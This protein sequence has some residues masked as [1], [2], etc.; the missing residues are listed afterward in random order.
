MTKRD[1]FIILIKVFGLYSIISVL[2]SV[3]PINISFV[4]QNIDLVG[5]IWLILAT[6]IIIGL[7]FLLLNKAATISDI[8]KLEK[9]F[10]DNQI[11]FNGLKSLDIIK[12]VVL[13]IGGFLFIENIPT[14]LSHTLFAFKS[15]IPQGLDYT[16]GNQS[17]IKYHR[18]EDY[19]YWISNGFNL[20][21]GYILITNFKQISNYL[22]KKIT[23]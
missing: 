2:F 20:L 3:L 4:I 1:L 15:S 21:I 13:I 8:L 10:D 16:Y 19:V 5:I 11:D 14:F 12:F 9:G 23:K 18:L 7:F 22:N 17:L 6:I